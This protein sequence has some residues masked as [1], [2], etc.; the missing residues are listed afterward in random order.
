MRM[1]SLTCSSSSVGIMAGVLS[2]I[3]SVRA[4]T[5]VRMLTSLVS[6]GG[7]LFIGY[8]C[9]IY[10]GMDPS[11]QMASA[12]I[13]SVVIGIGANSLVGDII[14]GVFLLMEG[15]VQVGDIVSIADFRERVED[16]GIRMTKLYDI[17]T[18]SSRSSRTK[19]FRTWSICRCV[20]RASDLNIRSPTRRIWSAWK[21]C[22]SGSSPRWKGRFPA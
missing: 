5:G 2:E 18:T 12:G 22:W 19:R 17:E 21:H 20:R 16:L 7:V 15:N 13:I 10:F 11:T 1:Y 4:A 9:L 3:L 14:A 8:R 6:Y